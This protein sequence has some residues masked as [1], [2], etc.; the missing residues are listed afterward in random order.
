MEELLALKDFLLKGDIDGA[1]GIVDELEEMSRDDKINNIR[2]YAVILL[3]HLIKQKV[4]NRTTRSW[5]LSIRNSIRGIQTKNQRRKAGGTYLN[6]EELRLAI[7]EAYPEA[8]DRASAEVEE[9]RYEPKELAQ[10]VNRQGICDRAM[11]L[12][13]TNLEI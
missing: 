13:S 8:V 6:T 12:I 5:E 10:L 4:E 7:S 3:M 1:L 11:I 9:G 2:S